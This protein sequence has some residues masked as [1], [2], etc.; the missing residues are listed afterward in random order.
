[1]NDFWFVIVN[2]T[3]GNGKVIKNITTLK[4]LFKKYKINVKI[5]FSEYAKHENKLVQKAIKEGFTKIISVGGDGTLHHIVN[6]IMSQKI[7][8]TTKIKLAVIP[9]GTGNDWVKTYNIPKNTEKAIQIIK[10]ENSFY[11]DIGLIKFLLKNKEVYFNNAAGIGFD[12][13][14][15]NKISSYKKLG[16]ISY[17]LGG[18]IGFLNYK[19]SILQIS[20]DN[21]KIDSKVF[22]LSIGLCKFSGGGMQLTN[23]KDHKNDLFDITL[24]KNIKLPKVSINIKKLYNGKLIHLKEVETF[25]NNYLKVKIINNQTPYIQADGELLGKGNIEIKLISKAINFIIP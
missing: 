7:I 14:V 3:S 4:N 21:K 8:D 1:M 22:M 19:K 11:Q 9:V 6:G 2:P 24:I 25:K 23:F 16:S 12:A 18:L 17:L 5:V 13:Y 15:V 10:K 20:I